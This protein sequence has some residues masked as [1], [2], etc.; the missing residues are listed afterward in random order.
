MQQEGHSRRIS[1]GDVY[2]QNEV[3][4]RATTLRPAMQR[5]CSAGSASMRPML[6]ALLEEGLPLP[7]Y[8]Q[9]LKAPTVSTCSMPAGPSR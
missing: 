3:S 2:H 8:E 1:Y 4:S 6:R 7:A 5:C 9:I